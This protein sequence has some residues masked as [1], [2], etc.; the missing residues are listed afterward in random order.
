MCHRCLYRY[1]R[2]GTATG[3]IRGLAASM[4]RCCSSRRRRASSYEAVQVT[5]QSGIQGQHMI[6]VMFWTH[7]LC[8]L[9]SFGSIFRPRHTLKHREKV[10][11]CHF[12]K[13]TPR[14]SENSMLPSQD[15]AH[16][17]ASTQMSTALRREHHFQSKC[18]PR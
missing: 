3:C 14:C 4:G 6:T 13:S 5:A 1:I 9:L 2:H 11:R 15:G 17:L 16:D 12:S 8:D 10:E 7:A 18:A